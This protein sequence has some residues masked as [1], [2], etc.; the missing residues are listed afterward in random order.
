MNNFR[1]TAL[2]TLIK[3]DPPREY[4]DGGAERFLVQGRDANGDWSWTGRGFANHP[5]ASAYVS[6]FFDGL[7]LAGVVD[8]RFRDETVPV[9]ACDACD[10]GCPCPD[11]D[12]HTR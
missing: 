2:V 4:V 9:P 8:V 3:L 10:A 6:A 12:Y 7:R 5:E 1:K 11:A